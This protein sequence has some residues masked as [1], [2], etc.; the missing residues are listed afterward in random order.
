MRA[1]QSAYGPNDPERLKPARPRVVDASCCSP[2]LDFFLYDWLTHYFLFLA[3][4]FFFLAGDFLLAAAGFFFA[5][6]GF[7][8]TV[9]FLAF[10]G[11]LVLNA[12]LRTAGFFFGADGPLPLPARSLDMSSRDVLWMGSS[13]CL[14]L[15]ASYLK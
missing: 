14:N 9:F 8:A 2:G 15:L 12:G 10:A 3:G 7:F 6:A 11:D 1:A 13:K 4:D 5:A